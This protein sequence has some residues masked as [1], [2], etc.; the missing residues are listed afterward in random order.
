MAEVEADTARLAVALAEDVTEI[1]Y[2]PDAKVDA[3]G[4]KADLKHLRRQL[5]RR[6]GMAT[7]DGAL[8]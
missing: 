5:G 1:R 2:S 4:I 6:H 8:R 3:T 7:R